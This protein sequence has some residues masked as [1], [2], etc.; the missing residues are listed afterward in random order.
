MSTS[1]RPAASLVDNLG[2]ITPTWGRLWDKL[3]AQAFG[4]SVSQATRLIAPIFLPTAAVALYTAPGN[5]QISNGSVTN[6][7]AAAVALNIYI[8]PLGASAGNG[9]LVVQQSI[10]AN[11]TVALSGLVSQIVNTG[12]TLQATSSVASALTLIVSGVLL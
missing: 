10:P 1:S 11:S 5:V 4:G 12:E 8:V 7:T 3:W 6:S 2:R 9:N